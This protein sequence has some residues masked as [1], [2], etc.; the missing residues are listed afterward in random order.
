MA[1][2][3]SVSNDFFYLRSSIVPTFSIATCPMRCGLNVHFSVILKLRESS[4]D[5]G[6]F[7]HFNRLTL[8]S[9]RISA[10][11]HQHSFLDNAISTKILYAG[12]NGLFTCTA[13]G[14][15]KLCF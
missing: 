3:N 14:N 11:S 4:D 1:I 5:S 8:A 12:R 6:E 13:N 15:R 2:K 7:A 10:G 9:K